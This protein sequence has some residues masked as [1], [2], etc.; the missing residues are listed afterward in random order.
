MLSYYILDAISV[1]SKIKNC[2]Y[3]CGCPKDTDIFQGSFLVAYDKVMAITEGVKKY[4]QQFTKQDIQIVPT[5]VDTERF[6]PLYNRCT[7]SN[8][9]YLG[10]V[11]KRKGIEDFLE[12]SKTSF[13]LR[14]NLI[15]TVVGDGPE[16]EFYK[17]KYNKY[18]DF[19]KPTNHPEE[20]YKK[21][22]IVICPSK[23]GE[24]LQGVILEAMSSGCI[25][26]ATDTDINRELLCSDRGFLIGHEARGLERC[27]ENICKLDGEYINHI[28][29]NARKYIQKNYSWANKI[30]DLM[31]VIK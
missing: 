24:G 22:D 30:K 17:N 3:L 31:E 1:D 26:V 15:F 10:R 13:K 29:E 8:V 7:I 4:W 6:S 20:F 9:L 19:I 2:L 12:V 25:I 11:I 18:T 23:Y 21:N 27:L 28:R 5:G 14:N 16:I